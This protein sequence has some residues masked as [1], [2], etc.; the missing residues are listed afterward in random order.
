MLFR[1]Y[2][3]GITAECTKAN[4]L[5]AKAFRR[6]ARGNPRHQKLSG[7][8]II[9]NAGSHRPAT[10]APRRSFSRPLLPPLA[11]SDTLHPMPPRCPSRYRARGV[12]CH[13][14]NYISPFGRFPG[15]SRCE[16]IN[17]IVSRQNDS[18]YSHRKWRHAC[19]QRRETVEEYCMCSMFILKFADSLYLNA[20]L[21]SQH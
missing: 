5:T 2:F 8:A 9:S 10:D 19:M 21:H 11:P 1:T 14:C 3:R 15:R 6:R 13:H 12:F 18:S 20:M 4:F 7:G 17:T 16:N